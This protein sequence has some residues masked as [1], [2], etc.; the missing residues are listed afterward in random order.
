MSIRPPEPALVS[1]RLSMMS[2]SP[3]WMRSTASHCR[4]PGNLID[5]R[6]SRSSRAGMFLI[7]NAGAAKPTVV[8]TGRT[9]TSTWFRSPCLK[10][11]VAIDAVDARR[12]RSRINDSSVACWSSIASRLLT[13]RTLVDRWPPRRGRRCRLRR[14]CPSRR[15]SR[16]GTRRCRRG[17]R[18]PGDGGW[19]PRA[20]GRTGCSSHSW[21]VDSRSRRRGGPVPAS[22]TVRRE[23]QLPRGRADEDV[24]RAIVGDP[25]AGI[26]VEYRHV[27]RLELELHDP[28]FAG[29][30][31]HLGE[32]L[33]LADRTWHARTL[34]VDVELDDLATGA[35]ARVA[36][37]D[38]HLQVHRSGRRSWRSGRYRLVREG[39]VGQP[40]TERE[41][42][43]D[44]PRVVPP[45]AGEDALR[46]MAPTRCGR[47]GNVRYAAV[48]ARRT[49]KV[50]AS[51][52]DGSTR[53]SR[54]SAIAPPLASPPSH[55]WT[56]AGTRSA[57]GMATG[58]PLL[59]T[60]T[61]CG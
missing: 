57:H 11:S 5:S 21:K 2:A 10:S 46:R 32:R 43:L 22:W 31:R 34:F 27:A 1:P 41:E 13:H 60:T 23:W 47:D 9:S 37:R 36:D 4:L 50:S 14:R 17:R 48:S 38:R 19:R 25:C 49:G 61:T 59:T 26:R 7:V 12:N 3:G 44:L 58:A 39:R 30:E 51:R 45:V 16:A 55:A 28:R 24:V 40:V 35:G 18:H 20:D 52:P 6:V 15:A 53:P 56:I 54:T 29:F 42:R 8:D 33:Q